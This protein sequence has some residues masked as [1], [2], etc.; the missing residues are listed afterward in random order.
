MANTTI[1][2]E[3]K[4][5]LSELISKIRNSQLRASLKVNTEMLSLYWDLGKAIVEKQAK[6]DWGDK[7]ITQLATDLSIEFKEKGFSRSNLFNIRKW[8]QFYSQDLQ[9]VQQRV[10]L[11]ETYTQLTDNQIVQQRVDNFQLYWA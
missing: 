6:S 5:W 2:S 4:E 1:G 9:L 7:V 8:Y 3:Y 11:I 10:E